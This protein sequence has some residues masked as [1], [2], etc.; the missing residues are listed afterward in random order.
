[1]TTIQPFDPRRTTRRDGAFGRPRPNLRG[2]SE[3]D[4]KASGIDP[5]DVLARTRED[6]VSGMLGPEWIEIEP[7]IF[8]PPAEP[9]P[10]I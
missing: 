3:N 8:M 2:V 6:S 7:G 10:T 9:R 5:R 4:Q 1:M